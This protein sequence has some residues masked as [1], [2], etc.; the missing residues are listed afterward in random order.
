M[1]GSAY[2]IDAAQARWCYRLRV[3]EQC[4]RRAG[5]W[6]RVKS[7]APRAT[8]DGPRPWIY[9]LHAPPAAGAGLAVIAQRRA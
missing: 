3:W 2:Y 5:W 1:L 6:R 7:A 9:Q 8:W 4:Q